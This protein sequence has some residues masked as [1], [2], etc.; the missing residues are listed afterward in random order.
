MISVLTL[1]PEGGSAFGAYSHFREE[2]RMKAMDGRFDRRRLR[3]SKLK[4]HRVT[5]DGYS[6]A[7]KLEATVYLELKRYSR[8][9]LLK[10]LEHQPRVYLTE[11][12]I[13]YIPDFKCLDLRTEEIFFVEAKGFETTDWKIKKRLW[14]HYGPANLHIWKGS[15][16]RPSISQIVEI[17]KTKQK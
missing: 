15:F 2:G 10:I 12:R 17:Q 11:A 7:S 13:L 1:Y 9:A 5:I 14:I 8:E 16:K 6:F 4:N 3:S